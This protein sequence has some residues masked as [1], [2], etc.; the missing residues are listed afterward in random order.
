MHDILLVPEPQHES[1]RVITINAP[2][3]KVWPWL[4]QVGQDKVAFYSYDWLENL[5]GVG[6]R[7]GDKIVPEWQDLQQIGFIRSVPRNWL[8]GLG[9]KEKEG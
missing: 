6:Y 8:F 4:I 9:K 5:L 2:S 3:E 1:L 7:N